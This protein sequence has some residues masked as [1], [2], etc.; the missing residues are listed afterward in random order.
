MDFKK[1]TELFADAAFD[2]DPVQIYEPGAD[3]PPSGG[4]GKRIRYIVNDVPVYVV[5][6]RVQYYGAD[7]RLIT[8][9]LRDYTRNAVRRQFASHDAFLTRWG[10]AEQKRAIIA[11]LEGQGVLLHALAKQVGKEF[12]PFDL[13]AHVAFDQPPLTRRERVEQV[14]KRNYFARYGEQARAVLDTLL[15]KYADVGIEPME[16]IEVLKVQPFD[17]LSSPVELIK[18]FGGKADYLEAVREL[19]EQLYAAA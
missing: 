1:A 13:V 11:E 3:D 5:A 12:D 7:G 19:R 10:K 9:S 17:R 18:R 6:E 14:R 8:E 2:G 16:S 15:E 4:E